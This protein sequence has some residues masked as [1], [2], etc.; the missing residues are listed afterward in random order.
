M[1]Y[2][3][4][5]LLG[6]WLNMGYSSFMS[7]PYY[8]TLNPHLVAPFQAFADTCCRRTSASPDCHCV[9]FLCWG[10]GRRKLFPLE[11]IPQFIASIFFSC[12]KVSMSCLYLL[13]VGQELFR[14]R[15]LRRCLLG[16]PP[17]LAGL[18]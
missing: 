14:Y 9:H 4:P 16:A 15:L 17:L 2:S 1:H 12:F 13:K 7:L 8:I 5:I 6:K 3:A 11:V 18:Q 10:V